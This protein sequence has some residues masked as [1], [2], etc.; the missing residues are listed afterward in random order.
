[1]NPCAKK[2]LVLILYNVAPSVCGQKDTDLLL[3]NE[4]ESWKMWEIF[5]IS[6]HL[7][8]F[9]SKFFQFINSINNLNLNNGIMARSLVHCFAYALELL[10]F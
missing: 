9:L 7:Q 8:L 10:Y 5:K 1:M 2:N 6:S 3:S 4:S